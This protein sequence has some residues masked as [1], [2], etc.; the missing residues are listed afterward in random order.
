MRNII[1]LPLA[2]LVAVA[3]GCGSAVREQ[4]GSSVPRRDLTLVTQG[5]QVEFASPLETRQL[6]TPRGIVHHS[7]LAVRLASVPTRAPVLAVPQPV[8]QPAPAPETPLND[9]ELLPGKTVTVIPVS[10]GPSAGTDKTDGL[11]E[12]R[13][14]TVIAHG[15]GGTCRGGGRGPGIGMPAPR[16]DF[17]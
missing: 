9:R 14:H 6:R 2:A 17:R 7:Q 3:A 16:P 8:V 15:G 5:S 12:E 10:I 11:P 1:L 13:G 4:A